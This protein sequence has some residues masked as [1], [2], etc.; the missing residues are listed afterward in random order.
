M[1]GTGNRKELGETFEDRQNDGL[2]DGHLRLGGG[3]VNSNFSSGMV[4]TSNA[5]SF[6]VW[7]LGVCPVIEKS[8]FRRYGGRTATH[9]D[10]AKFVSNIES[11]SG[12]ASPFAGRDKKSVDE[13]TIFVG[14][15]SLIGL[16]G[17]FDDKDGQKKD[18]KTNDPDFLH[19]LV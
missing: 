13:F 10:E 18:D 5:G 17:S 16:V 4:F 6:A 1:A 12:S 19:S 8:G 2:E 11:S 3:A 7:K 9:F 14:I 15:N